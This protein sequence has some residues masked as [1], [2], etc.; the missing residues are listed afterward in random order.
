M[1]DTPAPKRQKSANRQPVTELPKW[2][3][4]LTTAALG[5]MGI[6]W[7]DWLVPATTKWR[8]PARTILLS[9]AG[10]ICVIV[11]LGLL[12]LRLWLRTRKTI[13]FGVTWNAY[14]DPICSGCE[15]SLS[16]FDV[17]RLRCPVCTSIYQLYDYSGGFVYARSA[18]RIMKEKLSDADV[19]KMK[20]SGKF[21]F[22]LKET[23][24]EI[25]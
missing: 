2:I 8:I 19:Q 18:L 5:A 11:C 22:Y 10:A 24:K 20:E 23:P 4:G 17:T 12:C 25:S 6:G 1:A 7:A 3:V 9:A 16:R 21:A 13:R 14:G 15:G